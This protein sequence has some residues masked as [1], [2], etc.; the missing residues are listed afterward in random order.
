MA[1][2]DEARPADR[3]P[4]PACVLLD[5]VSK[6]FGTGAAATAAL[7][8]ITLSVAEGDF[9]SLTGPSGCG[10]TTLLGLIA[11]L[12]EPD[13]GKVYIRGEDLAGLSER[14]RSLLR[15]REVGIVFQNFNLLPRITIRRNVMWRLGLT[16]IRGAEAEDRTTT[17]LR[18]LAV[19][20]GTWGRY[21]PELSGGEQQRAAL[22]RALV[23]DP[24][25]LLADEPT[26]SLD[27]ATGQSIINRLR[28]LN[29]ERRMALILVTH[30]PAVGAFAQRTVEIRDGR[31]VRD[32]AGHPHQPHAEVVPLQQERNV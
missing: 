3:P 23:T 31:I 1:G 10:K 5:G 9:V 6:T 22:A 28:T 27:S 12:D 24:S 13:G 21:P 20:E 4:P 16:G 18:E 25:I 11:G 7:R 26:G 2:Q 29:V 32:I 14:R 8:S 17:A 30:D 19:P 15:L